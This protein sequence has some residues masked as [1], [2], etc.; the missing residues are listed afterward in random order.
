MAQSTSP[1]FLG[2][3]E[4][5]IFVI[6]MSPACE[7]GKW[8]LKQAE[9]VSAVTEH[10]FW[11]RVSPPAPTLHPGTPTRDVGHLLGYPEN[12]TEGEQGGKCLT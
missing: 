10:L 5:G 1:S 6:L 2:C 9:P 4:M 3:D 7:K 11:G 12:L 8:A